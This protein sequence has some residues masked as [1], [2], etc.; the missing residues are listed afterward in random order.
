M[1][2]RR[3]I[4]D[5]LTRGR[6]VGYGPH[7]AQSA[8]LRMPR[9]EGPH[10][11]MVT[12]H[13]GSWGSRY[14]KVVMRALAGDLVMRGW[15]VWNIEYR[16]LG[17]DGGWPMTFED[18]AAAIDHLPF[19][20]APL[21]L[22]RV[23]LLGHSAGGQLALWAASRPR[24]QAGAPG[25]P[26]EDHGVRIRQVIAQA[27][28]CD[29]TRAGSRGG[30]SA[31]DPVGSA[32][33]KLMGGTPEQVPQRYDVGDPLRL[34]PTTMPVLLVHGTLDETVPVEH[35]RTYAQAASAAGGEV[36]LVEIPGEAG[37]HRA[38]IDPRREAWRSVTARLPDPR[39]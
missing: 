3:L 19:V 36:E 26:V 32:A 20:P 25:A 13:G 28:V 30:G 15:A 12:V 35:S 27:A 34:V 6:N 22:E 39:E 18:V 10:P 9:G 31:A 5:L 2:R 4:R 33:A 17:G 24:L 8:D 21:D 37:R 11:V 23:S 16:R 14:G 38:H 1:A 7:R 29:L